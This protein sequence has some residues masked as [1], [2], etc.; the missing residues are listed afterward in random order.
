MRLHVVIWTVQSELREAKKLPCRVKGNSSELSQGS[1]K[2]LP[3]RKKVSVQRELK[4]ALKK[5]TVQM[6]KE[7]C[8]WAD[9]AR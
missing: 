8:I 5:V 7:P 2:K 4:G 1:L 9:L 6:K 3:S